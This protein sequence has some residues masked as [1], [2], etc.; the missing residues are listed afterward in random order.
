MISGMHLLGYFGAIIM[1]LSLGLI[2]GGGSILTV[3]VLVYLFSI[4]PVLATAYSLFIV[5]STSLVGSLSH[6]RLGNVQWRAA[7]IFGFPSIISVFL[8]R[9]FIMPAIPNHL[10]TIGNVEFTK[11][12]SLLVL[13]GFVMLYSAVKMIRYNRKEEIVD[14]SQNFK[15]SSLVIQ[16]TLVGVLAGLIGAGGGFLIIPALV[17]F[18]KLPMKKAIGTSLVII[19]SN[20]LIGFIG[21]LHAGRTVD[22][23]FLL[24]FTGVA[25]S[26]I[27]IGSLLSGKFSNKKLKTIFG[28]FVLCM[29]ITIILKE[30]LF[31]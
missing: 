29:G 15:I 3:P 12:I 9:Y 18:A 1:G 16:G 23:P 19:A 17:F 2:G 31:N 28:W 8:T 13:F 22:F 26:G 10:F 21:D 24:V 4:E 30:L 14:V 11:A 5:G 6:L 7:A 27:I 25:V 20:S